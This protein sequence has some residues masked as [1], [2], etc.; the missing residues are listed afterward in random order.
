[1]GPRSISFKFTPTAGSG[2]AITLLL[3]TGNLLDPVDDDKGIWQSHFHRVI[4]WT[5]L[6]D[7]DRDLEKKT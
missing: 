4:G 6:C 2:S 3:H 5:Y 7:Q 1:M